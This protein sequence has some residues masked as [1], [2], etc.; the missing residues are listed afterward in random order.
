MG[1]ENTMN[2]HNLYLDLEYIVF[3]FMFSIIRIFVT[4]FF[5]KRDRS[6]CSPLTECSLLGLSRGSFRISL[7]QST[8]ENFRT[9]FRR[10]CRTCLF[11]ISST[12]SH[13]WLMGTI[14]CDMLSV[15]CIKVWMVVWMVY[16]YTAFCAVLPF[17]VHIFRDCWHRRCFLKKPRVKWR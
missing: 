2:D 5:K 14:I 12:L 6:P 4:I 7:L 8:R 11:W 16:K 9:K 10:T 1:I 17:Q 15:P 13:C 3:F